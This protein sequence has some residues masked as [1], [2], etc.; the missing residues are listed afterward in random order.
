M[1][2]AMRAVRRSGSAGSAAL[3]RSRSTA[4]RT[5]PVV[6][7]ASRSSA[8]GSSTSPASS[9]SRWCRRARPGCEPLLQSAPRGKAQ[10]APKGQR[11]NA[12]AVVAFE[13]A[14][15]GEHIVACTVDQLDLALDPGEMTDPNGFHRLRR[16]GAV[17]A[18][19][20]HRAGIVVLVAIGFRGAGVPG[21]RGDA[22][23][24][25]PVAEGEVVEAGALGPLGRDLVGRLA[26][27][28]Q[29][30]GDAAMRQ[31]DAASPLGRRRAVVP[32]GLVGRLAA[33]AQGGR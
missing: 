21:A 32:G 4:R 2:S 1:R 24:T 6:S 10:R 7:T 31:A 23:R 26:R 17:E 9:T 14:E 29:P 28:G 30:A 11:H 8:V 22:Q 15:R 12:A 18:D 16:P 3:A 13:G 25:V 19:E 20:M 27:A 5:K 33:A